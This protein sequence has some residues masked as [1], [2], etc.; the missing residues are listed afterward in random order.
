MAI[1]LVFFV[2]VS[3]LLAQVGTGSIQGTVTD[4]SGAVILN[5]KVVAEHVETGNSFHT[6]SN[7]VGFFI[8]PS[9]QQGK[10]RVTIES[11]GMEKWEAELELE[12]GSKRCWRPC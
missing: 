6:Q 11:P 12:P 8:F 7:G 1:S 2:A 10:Y 9:A 3:A 4:S 5:A